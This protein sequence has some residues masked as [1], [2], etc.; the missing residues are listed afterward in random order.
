MFSDASFK[1]TITYIWWWK[2]TLKFM[3]IFCYISKKHKTVKKNTHFYKCYET[4]KQQHTHVDVKT[5]D[6]RHKLH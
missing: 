5:K 3:N 1:I 4:P 2:K 6:L